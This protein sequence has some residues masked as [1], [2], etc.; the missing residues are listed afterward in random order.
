MILLNTHNNMPQLRPAD[1]QAKDKHD[2]IIVIEER[3][4]VHME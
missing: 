4:P 3:V 2:D 1:T